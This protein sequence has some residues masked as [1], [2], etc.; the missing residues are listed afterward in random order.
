M[1]KL[2]P[3]PDQPGLDDELISRSVL[4]AADLMTRVAA[5]TGRRQGRQRARFGRLL[6]SDTGTRFCSHGRI[7]LV[8]WLREQSLSPSLHRYGNVVYR[9]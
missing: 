5:L 4:L 9:R 7:E 6:S 8:R 1:E 3:A 2:D